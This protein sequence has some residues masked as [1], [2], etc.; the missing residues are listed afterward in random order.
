MVSSKKEKSEIQFSSYD[1]S[2]KGFV[3][4]DVVTRT[5]CKSGGLWELL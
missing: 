5:V 1:L 4:L 3:G 2:K